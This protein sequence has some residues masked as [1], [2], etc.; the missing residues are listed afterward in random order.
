[1]VTD[2]EI[3]HVPHGTERLS[4]ERVIAHSI[5]SSCRQ[6]A[7]VT[8]AAPRR[9]PTSCSPGAASSD[10]VQPMETDGRCLQAKQV[11]QQRITRASEGARL[12]SRCTAAVDALYTA[13]GKAGDTQCWSLV[14]STE[15]ENSHPS[16][17]RSVKMRLQQLR[18]QSSDASGR[19]IA[20]RW[21]VGVSRLLQAIVLDHS[22]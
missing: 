9:M 19:Q 18:W 5:V 12:Q 21:R 17:G 15:F 3:V 16:H 1:M 11:H 7:P 14:R 6:G 13:Q 2:P 22:L 8:R 10:G 20:V 4:A